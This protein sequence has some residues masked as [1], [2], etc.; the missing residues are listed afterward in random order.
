MQR[1]SF[2]AQR[3]FHF[4]LS[5]YISRERVKRKAVIVT[6]FITT[7]EWDVEKKKSARTKWCVYILPKKTFTRINSLQFILTRWI[8]RLTCGFLSTLT[9]THNDTIRCNKKVCFRYFLDAWP[10]IHGMWDFRH[11]D[12]RVA[13]QAGGD[14]D[15]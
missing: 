4:R 14:V 2:E 1:I 8:I 9:K 12:K 6:Y 10:T 11:R 13:K 7:T 15:G 5:N 3:S